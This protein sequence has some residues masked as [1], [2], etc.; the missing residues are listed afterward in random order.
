MSNAYTSLFV[1][2][3][4]ATFLRQPWLNTQHERRVHGH[5]ASICRAHESAPLAVGSTDDHVHILVA[6]HPSIAVAD[7]VRALKSS[8]SSMI[9]RELRVPEFRWQS[10]YGAFTIRQED[11][12]AVVRYV[13]RQR[14]V[15]AEDAVVTSW[16]TCIGNPADAG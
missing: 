1:H 3:N 5:L 9:V 6:L 7:L 4:W 16:E 11:C 14:L 15:H 2:L 13:L 8:S 10:G 12:D